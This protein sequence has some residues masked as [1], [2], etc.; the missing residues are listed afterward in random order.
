[1][2]FL[3][4]V[5][6][7]LVF[8][9][10]HA[11]T[12][13][14]LNNDPLF[15]ELLNDLKNQNVSCD[16]IKTHLS[17]DDGPNEKTS[18]IIL[19]ELNK[20]N[21]KATFFTTTTNLV[22]GKPGLRE[23]Q[24]ILERE[25]ATGHTVASHGHEHN[26]YDMRITTSK[27][28]GYTNA[29]REDQIKKSIQ[30]LDS[31]T[32]GKFSRQEYKL[33]RFPYGRGAMPSQKEI[34]EMEKTKQMVFSGDSYA[35]KL[36]EY[37]RISPAL[38]QIGA[39]GFSHVGWNHDSN[40][41]SLP[42]TMPNE[43]VFKAYVLN[44]IKNMCSPSIKTKVSLFHDIKEVNTRAIPLIAD[45]GGC[46]GVDFISPKEMMNTASLANNDVIIKSKTIAQAPVR[47]A[48]DLGKLINQISNPGKQCA[49]TQTQPGKG[50]YSKYLNKVFGNCEGETSKCFEG[51]WYSGD[52]PFIILNCS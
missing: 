3:L 24:A 47:M 31:A 8:Q 9:N 2:P 49:E 12:C 28:P 15:K 51:K 42:F 36:K 52:D 22:S 43:N 19:D 16:G 38:Q 50:C 21:I 10:V 6:S 4:F 40:D 29:Q 46:L 35:E 13:K 5:F 11:N 26:A 23:K 34:E 39:Y 33:F 44:N 27:E 25:L 32:N 17:F 30:L 18:G 7:L 48:D 14:S 37:R 20:R 45:L 1:M 41:S